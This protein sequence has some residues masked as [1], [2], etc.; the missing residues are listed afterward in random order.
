[1]AT[2]DSKPQTLAAV[3]ALLDAQNTLTLAT[4]GDD[5][6]W[7]AAVFFA[8]DASLNL[9]F[10]S[11]ARTRH[12]RNLAGSG[13][14]AVAVHADCD[15]WGDI[16]GVQMEGTVT[17]LEGDHRAAALDAYLD[18][19]PQIRRLYEQPTSDNERTIAERL[20]IASLYR[21]APEQVRMID[22]S[23]GF[24]FKEE[25]RPTNHIQQPGRE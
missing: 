13:R 2:N 19:F 16:R 21:L 10:V 17:I 6:P 22:N 5:G 18:K 20:R 14:A 8:S 12:G 3:H 15:H 4:S 11:D 23:R 9:Y 1:M 7:A 25:F 24:G